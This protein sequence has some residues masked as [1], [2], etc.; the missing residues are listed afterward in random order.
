M[1]HYKAAVIVVVLI[2]AVALVLQSA[3]TISSRPVTQVVTPTAT[4]V[5]GGVGYYFSLP[6]GCP[7]A[8]LSSVPPGTSELQVNVVWGDLPT[9]KVRLRLDGREERSAM[10]LLGKELLFE[11]VGG[12]SYRCA[13]LGIEISHTSSG[14]AYYSHMVQAVDDQGGVVVVTPNPADMRTW[15][16]E[17]IETVEPIATPMANEYGE[18]AIQVTAVPRIYTRPDDNLSAGPV[19]QFS[20]TDTVYLIQP[21]PCPAYNRVFRVT[22]PSFTWQDGGICRS[23]TPVVCEVGSTLPPGDYIAEAIDEALS[24]TV[25]VWQ[26]SVTP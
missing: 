15:S 19:S 12:E 5:L 10:P 17:A 4:P 20:S 18:F 3:P 13:S 22:G 7:G 1:R 16:F 8:P 24:T 14:F 23:Y 6:G 2:S 9:D 26:F 11:R 25:A 21:V